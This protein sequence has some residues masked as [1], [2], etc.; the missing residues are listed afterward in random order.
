[1]LAHVSPERRFLRIGAVAVLAGLGLS[2][3][4]VNSSVSSG[5]GQVGAGL[6]DAIAAPLEDLNLRR[7]E[8][9]EILIQA[10]AGPYDAA[11]MTSCARIA[12]EIAALDEALGSDVDA[13]PEAESSLADRAADEAAEATLDAVRGTATDFIPARSWVRRLTGAEQHSR[14]VQDAVGA[15]LRRRAFLKGMGQQRNCAPP[16]APAGFTPR[17]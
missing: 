10:Q 12:T 16:A 4:A 7:T 14:R 5:A 11:G 6:G 2:A 17:R 15:G 8:I 13:P 3:C 1:M 9:P